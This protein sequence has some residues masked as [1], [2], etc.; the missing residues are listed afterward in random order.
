MAG[1]SPLSEHLDW[2]GPLSAPQIDPPER[3]G[4]KR[5]TRIGYALA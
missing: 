2:A 4:Y 3:C 1:A 5:L